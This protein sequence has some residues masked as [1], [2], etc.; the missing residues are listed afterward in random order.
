[1]SDHERIWLSTEENSDPQYEGR[2]WCQDRNEEDD[3]EYIRADL[4]PTLPAMQQAEAIRGLKKEIK[5]LRGRNLL[6]TQTMEEV[7]GKLS[8]YWDRNATKALAS[9]LRKHLALDAVV[10]DSDDR[11]PT[12]LGQALHD[13]LYRFHLGDS[14]YKIR[15][16]LDFSEFDGPSSEHPD[17]SRYGEI[18][19]VIHDAIPE[20]PEEDSDGR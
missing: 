4:I 20:R 19:T 18:M 7:A 9:D 5:E 13:L 15:E 11:L 16:G 2:T 14:W 6:H 12:T 8:R 17:M 1:M 10:E 3:T